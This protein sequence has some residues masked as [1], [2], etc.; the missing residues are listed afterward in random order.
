MA[1]IS[2]IFSN[3][4]G[5]PVAGVRI[6]LSSRKTTAATF[7]GTDAGATTAPDGSYTLSVVTGIYAVSTQAGAS[8][9]YLG[10]IQVYPDSPDGT[11]NEYLSSFNPDDLTPAVVAEVEELVQEAKAAAADAEQAAADAR[12]AAD[13]AIAA[14]LYPRGEYDPTASYTPN[15]LV[16]FAGSEYLALAPVRGIEPPA[17]PWD[18]FVEKG[19]PGEQGGKGEDGEPGPANVLEVGT[20]DTLPPGSPATVVITG[21]PPHQIIDFGIP[22]GPATGVQSVNEFPLNDGHI[23]LTG[24]NF[25][26]SP[27]SNATFK[28]SLNLLT[29]TVDIVIGSSDYI[30][31]LTALENAVAEKKID[32]GY[33][34]RVSVQTLTHSKTGYSKKITFKTTGNIIWVD[35]SYVASPFFRALATEKYYFQVVPVGKAIYISLQ[36]SALSLDKA[37]WDAPGQMAFLYYHYKNNSGTLL[38]GT[39]TGWPGSRFCAGGIYQTDA[40]GEIS[41]LNS[42]KI[43]CGCWQLCSVF[44]PGNGG[45]SVGL[46]QRLDGTPLLPANYLI[47]VSADPAFVTSPK[48]TAADNSLIDVAIK[49]N[50]HYNETYTL[51]VAATD[52]TV[53]GPQLYANAVAGL[54]GAVTAYHA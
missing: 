19:A 41:L 15:D 45:A 16:R 6:L 13:E 22:Q 37:A 33:L 4:L 12:A 43:P 42:T 44:G 25:I 9:D 34:L 50:H 18:L 47:S 40:T 7:S 38:P 36:S 24:V 49:F 14:R 32:P 23:Q 28:P 35:G 21:E 3:P 5:V 46:A 53:Y 1:K 20:V 39:G 26:E 51:T 27:E 8:L 54:F 52:S 29:E 17:A 30:I 31:D 10:V 11:L 2:G 48:Y